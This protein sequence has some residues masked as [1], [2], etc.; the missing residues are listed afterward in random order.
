MIVQYIIKPCPWCKVTPKLDIPYKDDSTWL[1]K[2]RCN[3]VSCSVKP[4][5]R[6]VPVR[7]TTK[8]NWQ[9]FQDKIALAISYWNVNNPIEPTHMT[10]VDFTPM[11]RGFEN[12]MD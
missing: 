1:I 2:V 3:S 4:N 9:K 10:K 5:G 11:M 6:Y 12:G 7:N 8:H